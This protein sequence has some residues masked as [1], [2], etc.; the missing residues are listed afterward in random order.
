MKALLLAALLFAASPLALSAEFLI[1]YSFAHGTVSATTCSDDA[2]LGYDFDYDTVFVGPRH[3]TGTFE[4]SPSIAYRYSTGELGARMYA[5]AY[6]G[7]VEA[8]VVGYAFEDESFWSPAVSLRAHRTERSAPSAQG[9]APDA[10]EPKEECD[11]ECREHLHK[12]HD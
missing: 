5:A 4:F 6:S 3:T 2:C 9:E 8:G 10:D 7:G 11:H 12:D 1:T